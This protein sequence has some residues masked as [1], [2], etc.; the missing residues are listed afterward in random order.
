MWAG[1]YPPPPR[2]SRNAATRATAVLSS[3]LR[4]VFG[5]VYNYASQD[6][7]LLKIVPD[8][9]AITNNRPDLVLVLIGANDLG[10]GR[11][12]YVVATNDMPK[13]LDVIFSNAPNA[14]ALL[15]KPTML[16]NAT[17]GGYGAYASN[18]PIYNAALQAM[19][20]QRREL[21]QN[22]FL[23][24]MYSAVDYATMFNSDH[25]HPN[26]LGLQAIAKEWFSR[27]K[28]I[29]ISTNQINSVLVN[30]G[31]VWKY[32]D[33]GQDLGTN[34][35]QPNYDDSG[36]NSGP[37]RLGY[38]DPAVMTTIG[39]GPEP[40]NKFP[41]THFRRSFVVPEGVVVTNLNSRLARA[42]G[43]VVWLNGQ[44][45]FRTNLPSG[46]INYTNLALSVVP[47]LMG[48]IFY[49]MTLT[50]PPPPT[51]TN[52]IGVEIHQ[53]SPSYS[54]LGFDMELIA[55][56]YRIPPPSLSIAQAASEVQLSWQ[57][58]SG[59]GYSL[60]TTTNLTPENSWSP[61]NASAQTNGGQVVVTQAP[62]TATWFYRLQRP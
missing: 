19:V 56:G 58:L 17:V 7:Y 41:T 15:A 16:L 14:N 8:A 59:A 5:S 36:W 45:A 2:V 1:C 24:D 32:S 57:L 55:S 12:P 11:N 37:A 50:A 46:P 33:N 26:P 39:F 44:Q 23:A 42:S 20:N 31:A 27:I 10:R 53:Y 62:D 61:A 60:Y 54:T 9:L 3:L 4:G 18:V 30:G 40:T 28:A 47:S 25:L 29:S 22:V 34:W 51:G 21:G 13:L 48:N 6:N 38:G 35:A 49:P 43:A 52:M